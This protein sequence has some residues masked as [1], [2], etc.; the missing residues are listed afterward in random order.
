MQRQ[1]AHYD[2]QALSFVEEGFVKLSGT[3][4]RIPT[5]K[6]GVRFVRVTLGG[7]PAAIAFQ[8]GLVIDL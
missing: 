2:K 6:Q 5:Q 4:V 1:V 3:N 8:S 7:D